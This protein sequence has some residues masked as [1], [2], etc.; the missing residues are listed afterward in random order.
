L[1]QILNPIKVEKNLD[2]RFRSGNA[3]E[4]LKKLAETMKSSTK[5]R[6]L[7]MIDPFGMQVD[8]EAI[9]QL[10][11]TKTDLWILIP[12]GVIINRLLDRNRKLP[13]IDKLVSFF[14]LSKE[15]I[16]GRFYEKQISK[17]LFDIE[18]KVQKVSEPIQKI[19]ELYRQQLGTIFKYV[20]P[21]PLVLLNSRNVPIYHFAF[22]SNNETAR[23]IASDII[24]G[25]KK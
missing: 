19:A 11:G 3:N 16:E 7:A 2:L 12:S 1:E 8:W 18:D 10:E 25:G 17:G 21:K 9:K 6:S 23:R 14:G 13:Y 22:A 24:G 15:E 5:F 4:F 20:T